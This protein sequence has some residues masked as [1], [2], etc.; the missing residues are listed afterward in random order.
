MGGE[1]ANEIVI[2]ARVFLNS[3]FGKK[4]G[5]WHASLCPDYTEGNLGIAG[6][7]HW[8]NTK[9]CIF[10]LKF[11]SMTNLCLFC[12]AY[13]S[14]F[15]PS[16]NRASKKSVLGNMQPARCLTAAQAS[17]F[18][19]PV[20]GCL[21]PVF[22]FHM[23]VVSVQV[24]L[25]GLSYNCPDSVS[26]FFIR[27][28]PPN[29][30]CACGSTFFGAPFPQSDSKGQCTYYNWNKKKNSKHLYTAKKRVKLLT[31]FSHRVL[32]NIYQVFFYS[33]SVNEE[34]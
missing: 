12:T 28:S 30:V 3:H 32:E 17:Y 10:W 14:F 8:C 19:L 15:N 7:S 16:Q 33:T 11:P 21:D 34:N 25:L 31:K 6:I 26:C 27:A 5:R 29:A 20:S 2:S 4:V 22:F 1:E 9:T 23:L 24:K 13:L 18:S